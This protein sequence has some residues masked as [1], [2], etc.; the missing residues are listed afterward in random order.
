[1]FNVAFLKY[2]FDSDRDDPNARFAVLSREEMLPFAPQP[3]IEIQ[4]SLERPQKVITSTWNAEYSGFRCRIEDD[5]AD[6]FSIDEPNFDGCLDDAP[7][8]GW[9]VES[10]YP[11]QKK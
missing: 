4:W 1:M 8:R 3:G 10:V 6:N 5:Y 2:V 11:A 9:K 7:E